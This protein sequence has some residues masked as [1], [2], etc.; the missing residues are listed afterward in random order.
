[1][2][3]PT[4]P[5]INRKTWLTHCVPSP[6]DPESV[7]LARWQ[8]RI[9]RGAREELQQGSDPGNNGVPPTACERV[10]AEP[11]IISPDGR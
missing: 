10:C 1:M 3:K 7:R 5:R 8:E 9:Q 11:E 4:K 2:Y 6:E